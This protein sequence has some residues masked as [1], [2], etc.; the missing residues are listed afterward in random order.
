MRWRLP[1]SYAGI[2]LLAALALGA[3]LLLT[4]RGYYTQR[5]LDYL[6]GNARA[7]ADMMA[8]A[9]QVDEQGWLVNAQQKQLTSLSFLTQARVQ[10]LDTDGRVVADSGTPAPSAVSMWGLFKRRVTY[11]PFEEPLPDLGQQ[12]SRVTDIE[13]DIAITDTRSI[14][15]WI[16]S[17]ITPQVQYTSGITIQTGVAV[18]VS[19]DLSTTE[20]VLFTLP[21]FGTPFG[22]GLSGDSA[23]DGRRSTQVVRA[24]IQ[25]PEGKSIGQVQVSE[26]PAYGGQIVDSVA[27]GWAIASLV[28]VLLAAGVG[29]VISRHISTPL[30]ALTDVT[31]RM[32]AGDLSAR[33]AVTRRDELGT[34]ASSFNEMATRV[35]ETVVALR[36][37]VADAAHELHTPLTALR[38]NLELIAD[39]PAGAAR[40]RFVRRAQSQ[41]DR[42]QTLTGGLLDLS[43][44][45]ACPSQDYMAVDLSV[46]VQEVSEL[47]ASRAE[48]CGLAFALELPARSVMVQGHAAQLRRALGN[49]LDNALKF[50]AQ[51]GSIHV[52]MRRV[53]DMA[54]L[55]IEDTGIGIP[56]EDLPRLFS[57]F[58]RGRNAAAFP[59]SGLG[60]A[61]VKAIVDNHG[62]SVRAERIN[63][64]TRLVVTLPVH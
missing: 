51:G 35:E 61:I 9:A 43:R 5:E 63:A 18:T 46:L 12:V 62:G 7:I 13:K 50:T 32:A 8:A 49:L 33:A 21:A 2:A 23:D 29:F 1:L 44:V 19:G 60:L 3:V 31:A 4:V 40:A 39:E 64:G 47:Y 59:G 11:E 56:A 48:Q 6:T 20:D 27:R 42:L 45:E 36:H 55:C 25:T 52:G 53:D 34:L 54:E 30:V 24:L 57:R 41:V 15:L 22:F 16:R 17:D 28:A 58:H 10:L 37:F 26:G 38:T 14:I